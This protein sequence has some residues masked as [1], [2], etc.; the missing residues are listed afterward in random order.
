MNREEIQKV[1]DKGGYL[2]NY[3]AI[4]TSSS[5]GEFVHP[6]IIV[7]DRVFNDFQVWLNNGKVSSAV[8]NWHRVEDKRWQW[9]EATPEEVL[10]YTK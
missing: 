4:K 10:K 8:V 7:E 5:A 2:I 9:R 3:D 6:T 1:I